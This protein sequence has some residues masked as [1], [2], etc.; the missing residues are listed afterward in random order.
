MSRSVMFWLVAG[1][2]TA[3]FAVVNLLWR[4]AHG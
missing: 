3:W 1:C 4:L 2:A